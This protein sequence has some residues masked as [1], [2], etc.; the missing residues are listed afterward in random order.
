VRRSLLVVAAIAVVVVVVV[1]LTGRSSHAPAVPTRPPFAVGFNESLAQ[2]HH[3]P[4]IAAW[5]RLIDV[6]ARLHHN[7]GSTVL[8]TVLH[9][10]A[11]EPQPGHFD[12]TLPDE[13][14]SRYSA[15]GVRLLFVL[16]GVP[17][18][19]GGR[20]APW[21]TFVATV[22]ERYRGRI[23][24]IDIFNEPN[25]TAAPIAPRRYVQL[26][27]AAYAAVGH[28]V[29]VGGGA[30]ASG[31]SLAPYL[32]TMLRAGAGRCMD[33][34]SFHPYP[35]AAAVAS[36]RSDFA[37]TFAV[38]RRLRDRFAPGL[39]LWVT[40]TGWRAAGRPGEL[41]QSVVLVG[42]LH[43]VEDMPEHDVR[44]LLFHT[45]V[46]DPIA[47]G[48]ADYGIVELEPDGTLRPRLA[49]RALAHELRG[50]KD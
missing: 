46:G 9:W 50:S 19:A 3:P 28:R 47:P 14:L 38:V 43:A 42:I 20:L 12:F 4:G 10:D 5:H 18:W 11:T 15:Q 27:C 22:A 48:G 35:Q 25:F 30:L 26:L 39:P 40:E 16:D 34:L 49:Y 24:G 7:V 1:W 21:R 36:P 8:R 33:A 13:L 29:A 31:P 41:L 2:T 17:R 23:A 6:D 37:R 32:T 44:L 45:L